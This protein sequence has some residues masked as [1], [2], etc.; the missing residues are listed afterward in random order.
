MPD[1]SVSPDVS[2]TLEG[3]VTPS[4]LPE[5]SNTPASSD[6]SA[7][8]ETPSPTEGNTEQPIIEP[9]EAPTEEPVE[10]PTEAPVTEPTQTLEAPSRE[11]P[12]EEPTVAPEEKTEP[13]Q[14]PEETSQESFD[15]PE[16]QTTTEENESKPSASFWSWLVS[17]AYA[18]ESAPSS[19]RGKRQSYS[20]SAGCEG[21]TY[22]GLFDAVT[23]VELSMTST[24]IKENIIVHQYTGNHVYA[25]QM[26]TEGLTAVQSGKEILLY[27][28]NGDMMAKVEAPH[29]SDA[30]GRY[31][32]DIAVS[33]EGGGGTYRVTY[34]PNDE[35]MQSAAYPVTIDPTGNYFKATPRNT[36][37]GK[38]ESIQHVNSWKLS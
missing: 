9:T 27:N 28:S 8:N 35:W 30:E 22:P 31:S 13:V 36:I 23:D 18:D 14:S 21:I 1:A 19:I 38:A 20:R 33:L 16:N 17:T 25:Y 32:T 26:T 29:M 12:T 24:G 10:K 6:D 34:R 11:Q 37:K 2:A 3:A 15:I 4:P 7:G 5:V